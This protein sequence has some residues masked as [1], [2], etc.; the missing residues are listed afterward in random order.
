MKQRKS[1]LLAVGLFLFAQVAQADWQPV[2]RLTWTAADSRWPKIAVDSKKNIHL[3]WNEF[4]ADG[5]EVYYRKS[6]DGGASWLT[7]RRLTVT[8]GNSQSPVIA[9]DSSDKLHVV[10]DGSAPGNNELFYKRSLDRGATW[11]GNK[12]LTWTATVS[13]APDIVVDSA[14]RLHL[15]WSEYISG[16]G[17]VFYKKSTDGG[18]TWSTNQRL[19]W[20][21]DDSIYPAAAVDSSNNLHV[22][23]HDKSPGNFEIYHKKSTDGGKTWLP[24]QRLSW[25][26][27][28]SAFPA[29]AD[30]GSGHL[31][32]VWF[33]NTPGNSEIYCTRSTDKGATW[34][35]AKRITW[36]SGASMFPAINADS[37]GNLHLAWEDYTPGNY[38]I[39]YRKSNDGGNSWTTTERLT[40]NSGTSWE[41]AICV[42]TS[43]GIHLVWNDNTPGNYEIYYKKGN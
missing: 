3:I 33:D 18:T 30:D 34:S 20:T 43:F 6:T 40:W 41:P 27:D 4:L 7:A 11:S 26:P 9:V 38:E 1:I 24:S 25:T 31:L 19:T 12:R 21:A 32:V 17:E 37:F 13:S 42:D 23:W 14:D 28:V 10:W 16:K 39:F 15:F 35:T 8:E 36:N 29:I 22:V 5:Y 2:K